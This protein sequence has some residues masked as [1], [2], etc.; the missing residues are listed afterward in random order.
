MLYGTTE[1]GGTNFGGTVFRINRDGSGFAVL[2]HFQ[3]SGPIKLEGPAAGLV[4]GS[5]GA[6][7]GTTWGGGA[8]TNESGYGDGTVFRINK[9]GTGFTTL[10]SYNT[11]GVAGRH[12]TAELIE[13]S[14]GAL[15]GTTFGGGSKDAGVVFRLNKDGSGFTVLHDLGSADNGH[16]FAALV[17]GTD[18]ALYGTSYRGGDFDGGFVFRLDKDG[19]GYTN[20]HSFGDGAADGLDPESELLEGSDGSLYGTCRRGGVYTNQ[21]GETSG[22]VF[23]LNKEGSGYG[24]LHHF[25][26]AP[27]EGRLPLAGLIQGRDGALYG[28]TDVGGELGFGTLFKLSWPVVI[29]RYERNGDTAQLGWS[30]VP[31]WPYRI[32][33]RASLNGTENAW[34]TLG[35]TNFTARDGTGSVTNAEPQDDPARFYRI[36][37]P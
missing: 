13:G 12:P 19:T 7:Y 22:T 30:G 31:N 32:Q 24:I 14:N 21:W 3:F 33:T 28:A 25:G 4:E 37:W 34:M 27:G 15:Y 23:R 9:D 18:G 26:G 11:N 2:H 35:G 8:F 1:Q 6:L 29:T 5:D 16:G 17:E 36:A 20:L 10:H